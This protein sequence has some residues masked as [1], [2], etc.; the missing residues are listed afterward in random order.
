MSDCHPIYPVPT[1]IQG[2]VSMGDGDED[3]DGD[4][5]GDGGGRETR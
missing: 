4:G 1:Y 5:D 3:E 2:G